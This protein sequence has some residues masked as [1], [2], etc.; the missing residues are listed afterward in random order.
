[1]PVGGTCLLEEG[2]VGDELEGMAERVEREEDADLYAVWLVC[3]P[4]LGNDHARLC[5][6]AMFSRNSRPR[7]KRVALGVDAYGCGGGIGRVKGRV[8][9]NVQ[10]DRDKRGEATGSKEESKTNLAAISRVGRRLRAQDLEVPKACH[11]VDQACAMRAGIPIW[12]QRSSSTAG[13]KGTIRDEG[14]RRMGRAMLMYWQQS[15][16]RNGSVK[17][18]WAA[19]VRAD[20][21]VASKPNVIVYGIWGCDRLDN[22]LMAVVAFP[23]AEYHS[24]RHLWRKLKANQDPVSPSSS[25]RQTPPREIHDSIIPPCPAPGVGDG[26]C[27]AGT[28]D[29]GGDDAGDADP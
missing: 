13:H 27:D 6:G 21:G 28:E 5:A 20:K 15:R 2:L 8:G 12:N 24:I 11:K 17:G 14:G 22:I 4:S 9:D 16:R 23:N 3:L 1:M 19:V 10:V 18:V 29:E 7:E 26:V 25:I